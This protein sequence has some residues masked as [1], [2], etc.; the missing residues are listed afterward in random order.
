MTLETLGF[1]F[2]HPQK[3]WLTGKKERKMETK[4]MKISIMKITF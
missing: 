3:Q 2:Y 4:K 1:I